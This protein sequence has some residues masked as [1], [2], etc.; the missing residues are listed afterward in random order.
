M[1]KVCL[2]G[3]KVWFFCAK[4]PP[5]FNTKISSLAPIW[6]WQT[7]PRHLSPTKIIKH[8]Y[9]LETWSLRGF[10]N[11]S[12]VILKQSRYETLL[13]VHFWI[14]LKLSFLADE[15][16]QF[17]KPLR[18]SVKTRSPALLLRFCCSGHIFPKFAKGLFTTRFSPPP[19]LRLFTLN[20]LL[21]NCLCLVQPWSN[22]SRRCLPWRQ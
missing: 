15:Q 16:D 6:P 9:S 10:I 8:E 17:F 5:D 20:S 1:W 3:S 11:H 13:K 19:R 21:L 22:P 2:I 14:R 18:F 7:D 12:S 4:C